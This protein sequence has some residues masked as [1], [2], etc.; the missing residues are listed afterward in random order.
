[1]TYFFEFLCFWVFSLGY[2]WLSLAV[3]QM[4]GKTHL[5]DDLL[6]SSAT[7]NAT[8]PL[9]H[10]TYR[11]SITYYMQNKSTRSEHKSYTNIKHTTIWRCNVKEVITVCVFLSWRGSTIS[12]LFRTIKNK[13]QYNI[14]HQSPLGKKIKGPLANPDGP[15]SA[16]TWALKRSVF[17]LCAPACSEDQRAWRQ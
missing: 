3:E 7:L 6:V 2:V 10:N 12:P 15:G 17:S 4:P 13:N 9:A 8:H 5:R 14:L 1:M 16:G 11:S